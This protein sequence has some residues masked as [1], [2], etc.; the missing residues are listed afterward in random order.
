[1]FLHVFTALV[2]GLAAASPELAGPPPPGPPPA[3]ALFIS[4]S[5]EPFRQADGRAVWFAGADANTDGRIDL[6]EFRADALRFFA[7]LDTDKDRV[8]SG[9]ENQAYERDVAPEITR[10]AM[11]A[12][13]P[14]GRRPLPMGGGGGS[15]RAK[16]GERAEIGREG[17]ARFSMLNEPQPVRGADL[18]LDYRV[19]AE[20]WSKTAAKRF[21][22]LDRDGDGVLTLETLPRGPEPQGPPAGGPRRP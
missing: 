22:I 18:N 12:R 19:S 8:V 4:P 15:G 7:V 13:G 1:M 3:R 16:R 11:D 2:A 6:P 21:A 10:M 17:A 20:E 14:G 5:G 9:A